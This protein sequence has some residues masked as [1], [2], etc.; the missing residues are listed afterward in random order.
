M[1]MVKCT[2]QHYVQAFT[3]MMLAYKPYIQAALPRTLQ[4]RRAVGPPQ[5]PPK[6]QVGA[7]GGYMM[8]YLH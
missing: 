1:Y 8:Q 6:L 4:L 5:H 3:R 7:L 2:M